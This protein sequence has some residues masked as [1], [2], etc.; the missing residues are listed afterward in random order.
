M[1]LAG[2]GSL[3]KECGSRDIPYSTRELQSCLYHSPNAI[4]MSDLTFP[5]HIA[6][7]IQTVSSA[8][9]PVRS[10]TR[11]RS[12]HTARSRNL[13]PAPP[14]TAVSVVR[15]GPCMDGGLP[16][17]IDRSDGEKGNRGDLIVLRKL[18]TGVSA[19]AQGTAVGPTSH[20]RCGWDATPRL[21]TLGKWLRKGRMGR[22]L[23]C[24]DSGW[25][26]HL[27]WKRQVKG[28]SGDI[29]GDRDLRRCGSVGGRG[30]R[31]I[32]QRGRETRDAWNMCIETICCGAGIRPD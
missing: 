21:R 15:A 12:E 9:S 24:R 14:R 7:E 28:C 18:G 4:T 20:Q 23:E 29:Y 10:D 13:P 6:S 5:R 16:R 17:S 31:S 1:N 3:R 11:P 25:A 8:P 19:V 30:W 27:T 22:G 26:S 2:A 32:T